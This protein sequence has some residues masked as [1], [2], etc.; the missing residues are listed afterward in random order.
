MKKSLAVLAVAMLWVACG[1]TQ[2]EQSTAAAAEQELV[3]GGGAC[4]ATTCARG[5]FCCDASCGACAPL[6]SAC[7]DV[8]RCAAPGPQVQQQAAPQPPPE[9]DALQG[10]SCGTGTCGKGSYCCNPSCGICA[11][12]GAGCPDV[13]CNI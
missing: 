5:S 11:P 9:S 13:M 12:R 1:G 4:G 2:E 7:L 6:G 3:V 8:V 10:E